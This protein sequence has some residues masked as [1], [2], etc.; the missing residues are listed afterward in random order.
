MAEQYGAHL[1]YR[2]RRSHQ[3]GSFAYVQRQRRSQGLLPMY[4]G[5]DVAR[6]FCLC[7]GKDVARVFCL[8]TKAKTQPGS[9][10]YVQRQRRSHQPGSFA[11]VQRQR[12][13]QGLLP[14][15]KGKDVAR[16][17]CLSGEPNEGKNEEKCR[18][19]REMETNL[20]SASRLLDR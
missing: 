16:V 4:K 8:C 5:K 11:Y 14:M 7:T 2:Q 18:G 3:P 12:H 13:S 9:F 1:V 17:F 15:Y 20:F 6:V 10:A 19:L